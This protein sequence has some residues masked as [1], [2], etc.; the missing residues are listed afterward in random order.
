MTEYLF[1]RRNIGDPDNAVLQPRSEQAIRVL[2]GASR[3][4]VDA[5][6]ASLKRGK[7]I[8]TAYATYYARPR[9]TTYAR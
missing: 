7:E 3:R 1:Y 6:I 9:E 4:N 8:R 2:L 5:S